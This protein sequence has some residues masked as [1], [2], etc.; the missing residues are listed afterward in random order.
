MRF[1]QVFGVLVLGLCCAWP[2]LSQDKS[3]VPSRVIAVAQK[4]KA[5][6][7]DKKPSPRLPNNYGK[8]ELSEAQK[9]QVY[10][11]QAKFNGQIDALE[12]QIKALKDKRDEEIEKVLTPAQK[13]K[14]KT[15][16]T[17]SKKKKDD[18]KEEPPNKEKD[19][20]EKPKAAAKK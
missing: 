16:Q 8:L 13:Q 3:P 18:K 5:E 6:K 12:E 19:D 14:L 11:A 10:A 20:E 2:A 17:E 1:R 4:D 15:L 7:S 9:D